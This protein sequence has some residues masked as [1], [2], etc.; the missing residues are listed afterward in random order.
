M[1]QIHHEPCSYYA[2]G[3]KMEAELRDCARLREADIR[4][5]ALLDFDRE[6]ERLVKEYIPGE[7]VLDL[8]R[9]GENVDV[10]REQ[11]R[12]MAAQARRCGLNIDY[13]PTNFIPHGGL[14]WY[15]DYE[16]NEYMDEWSFERWGVQYWS[17]TPALEEYLREH[18]AAG[19]NAAGNDRT[20]P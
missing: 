5:P 10:P 6:A 12:E 16:C 19:Q 4:M 7:T 1:K 3:D 2:F 14:L 17:H 11:A 8:L 15:V 13:F 9:R 20:Q 18:P